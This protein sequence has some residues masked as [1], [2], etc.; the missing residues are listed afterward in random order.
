[1]GEAS[2]SDPIDR[3]NLPHELCCHSGENILQSTAQA[4]GMGTAMGVAAKV[5]G[6][7]MPP[8]LYG[9]CSE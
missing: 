2:L 1:M 5:K 3:R 4:V 7:P 8:E 9:D 6:Y